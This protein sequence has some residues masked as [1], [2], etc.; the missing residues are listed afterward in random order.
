[1]RRGISG[2]DIVAARAQA[3]L[4]QAELGKRL[5]VTQA[6]ISRWEIGAQEPNAALRR[7]LSLFLDDMKTW[8]TA[9]EIIA[10]SPFV[11][12][13]IARDW[14]LIAVSPRLAELNGASVT[15]LRGLAL[16]DHATAEMEQAIRILTER[17]F[18][19]GTPGS[20]RVIARGV[21][22]DGRPCAFDTVTTP[23]PFD[24]N[25]VMFHQIQ[26]LSDADYAT[27]RRHHD[28]VTPLEGA[29]AREPT[30]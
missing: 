17:G 29:R 6:T 13:L 15:A 5:G 19:L 4:S 16:K 12:A 14:T 8:R 1:M 11:M 28:L 7:K 3:G 26:F 22:S 25:I 23:I 21:Y 2:A 20:Y 18:F 10:H 27:L 24:R 30:S 9:E